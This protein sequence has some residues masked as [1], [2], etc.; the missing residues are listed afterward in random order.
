MPSG[1]K[2]LPKPMLAQIYVIIM[3]SLDQNELLLYEMN[4]PSFSRRLIKFIFVYLKICEFWLK[5]HYN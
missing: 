2:P 5:F 1:N 3:P 4:W